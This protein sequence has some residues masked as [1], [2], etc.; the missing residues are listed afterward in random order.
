MAA[1]V[2]FIHLSSMP[3]SVSAPPNAPEAAPIAAPFRQGK[4]P[5]GDDAPWRV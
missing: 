2:S 1:A 3:T 5:D 4:N